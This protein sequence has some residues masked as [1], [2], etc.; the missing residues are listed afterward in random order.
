M[1]AEFVVGKT[2]RDEAVKICGELLADSEALFEIID[3]TFVKNDIIFMNSCTA[4]TKEL[5]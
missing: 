2:L 4:I 5:K 1:Q 3:Q